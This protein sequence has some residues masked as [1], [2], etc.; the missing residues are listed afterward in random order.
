MADSEWSRADLS[1]GSPA[2]AANFLSENT[3]SSY[4][5]TSFLRGIALRYREKASV[6][7]E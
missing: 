2:L 6:T 5:Q 3:M 7:E 1:S 4:S